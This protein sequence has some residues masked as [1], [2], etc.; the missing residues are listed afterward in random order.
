MRLVRHRLHSLVA[1]RPSVF[2]QHGARQLHELPTIK[3]QNIEARVLRAMKERLF[4][5]CAFAE[6]CAGFTSELNR[7]HLEQRA[8]LSVARRELESGRFIRS[9]KRSRRGSPFPN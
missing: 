8:G 3:R 5:S 6:F 2:Q 7:L 4:E 1:R 9:P